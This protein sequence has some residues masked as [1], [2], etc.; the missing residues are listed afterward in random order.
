MRKVYQLILNMLKHH[1]DLEF[2]YNSD[3]QEYEL[4]RVSMKIGWWS[5]FINVG[6]LPQVCTAYLHEKEMDRSWT[7]VVPDDIDIFLD[8]IRVSYFDFLLEGIE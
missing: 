5:L 3:T 6:M 4:I 1:A 7:M 8:G 2:S